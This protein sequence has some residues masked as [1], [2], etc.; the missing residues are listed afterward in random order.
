MSESLTTMNEHQPDYAALNDC[1]QML[2]HLVVSIDRLR[3]ETSYEEKRGGFGDV[4]V[5]T[6]DPDTPTPKLVAAKAIRLRVRTREPQRIAF[7]LARELKVWAGLKHPHILPL[8]GFYLDE[9]YKNA[10]L[11]SEYMP[12]GDMKE[13]IEQHEPSW[14]LRLDLVRDITDGLAYLHGQNPP[15]RHGDLKTGNVLITAEKRAMLADFGLSKALAEGPTGLTTSESFKGTLRYCS[16]ELVLDKETG[17]SLS[18]DIWAW[19]CLVLEVLTDTMA[20]AEKSSEFSIIIA[21]MHYEPPSNVEALPIPVPAV[22]RLL[23]T[24]WHSQPEERPSAAHCLHILTTVLSDPHSSD[25]VDSVALKV[26]DLQLV[27]QPNDSGDGA[28]GTEGRTDV[29]EVA[30]TQEDEDNGL[31]VH[32]VPPVPNYLVA[33]SSPPTFDI[34]DSDPLD[35]NLSCNAC[36]A[37]IVGLRYQ[38]A[39]CPSFPFAYNLCAECEMKSFDVH[40]RPHVFLKFNRRVDRPVQTQHPLLPNIYK[41]PIYRRRQ[42]LSGSVEPIKFRGPPS[43]YCDLCMTIIEGAWYRCGHCNADL[44]DFHEQTHDATHVFL[45]IK[46]EVDWDVLRGDRKSVV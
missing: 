13:F 5:S 31:H 27:S 7:R 42:S 16:P 43:V 4:Q 18:S 34:N 32:T 21:L 22:K 2:K 28:E 45:V 10:V 36:N 41:T 40:P 38:C 15:I 30:V 35:H 14:E 19:A 3:T 20:Y 46:E 8:L 26:G 6:L 25:N 39:N 37:N 23:G 17:E 1:L 9:E 24:C 44:C 33:A 12:Y 29:N 11:I